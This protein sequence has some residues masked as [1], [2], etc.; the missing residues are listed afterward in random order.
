MGDDVP[1]EELNKWKKKGQHFGFPFCHAGDIPDPE[2][3]KNKDCKQFVAPVWRFKAHMAALGLRFYRGKQFPKQYKSQ[4]F[5]A[6]H[7]SWNRSQPHGYRIVLVQFKKGKPVAEKVFADGWLTE[8]GEVLGRPV[9][10]IELQ[11]G[12]LLVSDDH[13]GMIYRI[14]YQDKK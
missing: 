8:S 1:P 13:A 14:A 9:D 12:S 10:I 5:V 7:G 2:F 11:D 3:G 4:L 6:Q